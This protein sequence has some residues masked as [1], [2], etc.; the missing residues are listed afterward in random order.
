MV[1]KI[2]ELFEKT[3]KKKSTKKMINDFRKDFG[4]KWLDKNVEFKKK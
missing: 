2:K 1:I 3:R 4:S